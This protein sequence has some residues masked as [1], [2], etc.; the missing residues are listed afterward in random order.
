MFLGKFIGQWILVGKGHW[1]TWD[2]LIIHFNFDYFIQ[3]ETKFGQFTEVGWWERT[4]CVKCPNLASICIECWKWKW[5][6]KIS[7]AIQRPSPTGTQWPIK[8]T[9][10][11]KVSRTFQN[12]YF[13]TNFNRNTHLCDFWPYVI[14]KV[15][16]LVAHGQII[17][18]LE[19]TMLHDAE[20]KLWILFIL[21]RSVKE[22]KKKCIYIL[23]M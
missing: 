12:K 4:S 8:F 18:G 10:D 19:Y 17:F 5:M 21:C 23:I 7:L 9:M 22:K 16:D 11:I 6:F 2:I 3:R 15:I 14:N 1:I 13:V 20:G